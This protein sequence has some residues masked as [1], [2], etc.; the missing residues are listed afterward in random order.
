RKW[1]STAVK[2]GRGAIVCWPFSAGSWLS[3]SYRLECRNS[4]C[5]RHRASSNSSATVHLFRGYQYSAS[6]GGVFPRCC[7][8]CDCGASRGG[9]IQPHLVSPRLT[10]GGGDVFAFLCRL[11]SY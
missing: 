2:A 10:G 9:G 1:L 6:G 4:H 7:R 8:V 11:F 3:F 5:S